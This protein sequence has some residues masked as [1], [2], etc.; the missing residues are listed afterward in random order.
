MGDGGFFGSL[1]SFVLTKLECLEGVYLGVKN[2]T[3]HGSKPKLPQIPHAF[4]RAVDA[5]GIK[6]LLATPETKTT[7]GAM[8]YKDQVINETATIVQKLEDA[9]G[10]LV[11]KFTL[12]LV[13]TTQRAVAT[14]KETSRTA[15]SAGSFSVLMDKRPLVLLPAMGTYPVKSRLVPKF[16]PRLKASP[17]LIKR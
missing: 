10:V 13:P 6:D 8:P 3:T 14:L 5:Y 11:G 1:D 2:Q 17:V 7:W 12:P 15:I 16:P 4:S 9:G